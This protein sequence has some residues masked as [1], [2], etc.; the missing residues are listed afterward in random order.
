VRRLAD[1]GARGVLFDP[2]GG[3]KPPFDDSWEP[4]WNVAEDADVVMHFHIGS[5]LHSLDMQ[6]GTWKMAPGASV[7]HMQM[8]EILVGMIFAGVPERHPDLKF[9]LGECSIGWVPYVLEQMD[10]Q[11]E[12]WHALVEER[13]LPLRASDYFRRQ[14]SVTFEKDQVGVGLL[15]LIGVDNVMWASDYPHGISTFPRSREIVDA[16]FADVSREDMR[17]VTHDNARDLYGVEVDG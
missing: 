16:M 13:R 7:V 5:G 15:D 8:D 6:F 4:V 11:Q 10:F 1:H 9:V 2:W 17:K 14:F 3:P 12:E